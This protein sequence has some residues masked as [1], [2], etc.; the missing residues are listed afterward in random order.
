[1]AVG[2]LSWIARGGEAPTEEVAVKFYDYAPAPS[3]R[4]VRIFLA[5][6]AI[7]LPTVQVDLRHGEQFTE[8]FRAVNPDCTVPVLELDDGT[9]IADAVGICVYFEAARPA[10]P[11]MGSDPQSRAIIAAAQRRAER[12][13]FSAVVEAFR[14]STPG[15]KGRAI[16]GPDDYQQIPA[17]AERGR[18]RVL[19]F[20]ETME[21]ELAGRAFVCGP[22]FSIADITTL[23]TVDFAKWI[24]LAIP[25]RCVRLRRW[26]EAVSARPS[27]KA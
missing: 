24:K 18:A 13:G 9:R 27:A 15:M 5:E 22:D 6:K 16:P 20:F 26:H 17:L 7:T 3:P 8:A 23:V 2:S 1:M 21:A 11:L 25:E 12:E 19:R 10:P 14:N 4:R